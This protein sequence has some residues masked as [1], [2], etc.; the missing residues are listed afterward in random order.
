MSSTESDVKRQYDAM[1]E[2]STH[3]M[4]DAM[5]DALKVHEKNGK[6]YVLGIE[7]SPGV[8]ASVNAALARLQPYINRVGAPLAGKVL[9]EGAKLA[10]FRGR[11]SE[12]AADNIGQSAFIWSGV[13]YQQASSLYSYVT[14]H[15]E[16][17]K[18]LHKEFRPIVEATGADAAHNE[19]MQVEFA[20]AGKNFVASVKGM[21]PDLFTLAPNVMIAMRQQN[22][23]LGRTSV[24]N[25]PSVKLPGTDHETA[26]TPERLLDWGMVG[27]AIV[28]PHIKKDRLDD[29]PTA[30]RM[31]KKVSEAVRDSCQRKGDACKF[32]APHPDSIRVEGETL[33][34]Y[35]VD[36]F[37]QHEENKNRSPLAGANLEKLQDAAKVI[38]ESIAKGEVD[39]SALVVLVGEHKVVSRSADNT[40]VANEEMVQKAIQ[41]VATKLGTRISLTAEEF[42][43]NFSSRNVIQDEIKHNLATMKGIERASFAALLPDEVLQQAGMKLDE[44]VAARSS[45]RDHMRGMV[46]SYVRDLG[47]VIE[48]SSKE[49]LRDMGLTKRDIRNVQLLISALDSKQ[50]NREEI[51]NS[52][53]DRHQEVL[54]TIA[55]VM[56]NEQHVEPELARKS[57]AERV[58]SEA[59]KQHKQLK[60]KENSEV[61]AEPHE[62]ASFTTMV[63]RLKEGDEPQMEAPKA[64]AEARDDD[65]DADV[66]SKYS[67]RETRMDH[68]A[69]AS[70]PK[71]TG[72]ALSS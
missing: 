9:A 23:I 19:V 51:L 5:S 57:F 3:R 58:N 17:R 49:Q 36:I 68:T 29:S 24:L 43:R 41:N 6:S 26:L 48:T 34:Q 1:Q 30:W 72:I 60:D 56:L 46:E 7:L 50:E 70:Q 63:K 65:M 16:I 59:K 25:T 42:F 64:P 38:A 22:E 27:R 61:P 69:R 54:A 52:V 33:T 40:I 37:Q 44:I 11:A 47:D 31:I 13:F 2:E 12:K 14:D 53:L 8:A 28:D 71:D 21:A 10:G 45:A 62:K 32:D 55:T 66:T 20:R 67:A 39:A 4:Q 18:K 35:I 15:H